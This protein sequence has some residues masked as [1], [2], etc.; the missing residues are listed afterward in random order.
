[1]LDII[2][3]IVIVIALFKGYK[4]GLVIAIFSLIAL[5]VG[6]AVAVK[7]SAAVA[8]YF[9]PQGSGSSK[10]IVLLCFV[11]LFL[12]AILIVHMTGK[13]IE[14][15]FEIAFLGWANRL[16]GILLYVALY[17]IIFSVCLFYAD[18]IHLLG[19]PTLAE[20]HV[21]PYTQPVGPKIIDGIGK[22]IPIFKDAFTQ[23][24]DFFSGVS[25]KI[26]T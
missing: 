9:Q 8:S 4:K 21:Y 22:W 12:A 11:V 20:S 3:A 24:E 16:G 6:I 18:K 26:H 1:M 13:L 15:T 2:F 23:L 17:T 19:K 5:I 7:L 25:D 14:K 10:W